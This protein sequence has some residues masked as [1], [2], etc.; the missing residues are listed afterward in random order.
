M[1]CLKRMERRRDPRGLATEPLERRQCLSATI[2]VTLAERTVLEGETHVA[3]IR[4]SQPL[5][6]VE[7]VFVSTAGRNRENCL[8]PHAP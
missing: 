2:S 3:T 4:L 8:D 1:R 5:A 7:R 6:Q